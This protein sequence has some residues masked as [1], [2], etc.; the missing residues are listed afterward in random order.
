MGLI[1][2]EELAQLRELRS[3]QAAVR[4]HKAAKTRVEHHARRLEEP[5]DDHADA[6]V[7]RDGT[8]ADL[9]AAIKDA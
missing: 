7:R 3:H 6:K 2:K 1:T 8:K 4:S 5:E 9:V